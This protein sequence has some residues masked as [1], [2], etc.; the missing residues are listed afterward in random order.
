GPFIAKADVNA[1]GLEDVLIGG[2]AEQASQLF[3]QDP[4]KGFIKSSESVF[5]KDAAHEDI[6]G[7]FFDFDNDGDLD[8]YL[9]SGSG[10]FYRNNKDLLRDRIYV[11]DGQGNFSRGSLELLPN[12]LAAGSKALNVDLDQD[13]DQ[14]LIVLNRN[15]P[16]EYPLGPRSFIYEN[17]DGRFANVTKDFAPELYELEQMSVDGL[18]VDLDNNGFE[19]L[20]LVGEWTE[21]QI[22][23]NDGET[24]E[25]DDRN[26]FTDLKG[27]WRSIQAADLD[28]DG[29]LDLVLGNIG[30]N[31]K[32]HPKKESPL[33]LFYNDFDQNGYGDIVLSKSNGE[34]LLPVRGRECSS[35]QMPFILDKF[36]SYDA[37]ANANLVSIYS[38]EKLDQS[39]KLEVNNFHSGILWNDN[40]AFR[41][42]DLPVKAQFGATNDII[43]YDFNEDG[44]PDILTAGNFYGSEVETVRYDSHYGS[45]LINQGN[46]RFEVMPMSTTGL[47]LK[48]DVRDMEFIEHGDTKTLLVVS[49]NDALKAFSM[50][51]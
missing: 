3:I 5:N 8:I 12:D 31:N 20:I 48:S 17:R 30:L 33:Y 36:E 11:N 24:M 41:F 42:E 40:G 9:V 23:L 28:N 45:V 49:N 2:A 29:D 16:G 22:F 10:E 44:L 47:N 13:G 32:F 21:P 19:D 26:D 14:D 4:E 35:Q 6:S 15:V 51:K 39:L 34:E 46:Q 38:E 1:D 18:T 7:T 50:R 27:W 37:F 25:L 43:I